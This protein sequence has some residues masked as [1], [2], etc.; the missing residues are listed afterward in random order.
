[1]ILKILNF[2]PVF[3]IFSQTLKFRGKV[4]HVFTSLLWHFHLCLRSPQCHRACVSG[5]LWKALVLGSRLS[6]VIVCDVGTAFV[7]S[8]LCWCHS[9]QS[10]PQVDGSLAGN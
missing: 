10:P 5:K 9:E 6:V 1:M 7:S 3:Q 4:A 2:L 8:Q